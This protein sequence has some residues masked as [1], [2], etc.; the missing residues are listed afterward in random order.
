MPQIPMKCVKRMGWA[1]FL[2]FL[3]KGLLWLIIPAA[4]GLGVFGSSGEDAEPQE[5]VPQ[6]V[7]P[8]EVVPQRVQP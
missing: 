1:A 3:I 4:I 7:V 6:E 2:F 8:Q 5:P